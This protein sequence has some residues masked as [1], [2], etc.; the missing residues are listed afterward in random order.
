MR[1]FAGGMFL[2]GEGVS[3]FRSVLFCS[4]LGR[5]AGVEG[6]RKRPTNG[7]HTSSRARLRIGRRKAARLARQTRFGWSIVVG[8]AEMDV[9]PVPFRSVLFRSGGGCGGG[10]DQKT[11]NKRPT[12]DHRTTNKP[13][14]VT[15]RSQEGSKAREADDEAKD[16]VACAAKGLEDPFW[17]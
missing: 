2:S 8:F 17:V 6:T 3:P 16:M 4:V 14:Q 10:G 15:N 11:T 12:H 9:V 13:R 1:E 7:Q 5:D